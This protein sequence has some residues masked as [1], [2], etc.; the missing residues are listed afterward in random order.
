VFLISVAGLSWPWRYA[1][2]PPASRGS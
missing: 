1:A 2:T